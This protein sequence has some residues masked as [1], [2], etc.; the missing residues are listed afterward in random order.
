MKI[1]RKTLVKC[2]V[3]FMCPRQVISRIR[4]RLHSLTVSY[5][6]YQVTFYDT[7]HKEIQLSASDSREESVKF[8]LGKNIAYQISQPIPSRM[9]HHDSA[10]V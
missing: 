5:I 8:R 3:L 10:H 1:S 2:F 7:R 6:Q 4:F 9:V